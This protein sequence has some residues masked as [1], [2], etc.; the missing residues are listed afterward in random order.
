[1]G[2]ASSKRGAVSFAIRHEGSVS[3]IAKTQRYN[4]LLGTCDT[5]REL[6][7]GR[8]LKPRSFN[9]FFKSLATKRRAQATQ[10]PHR[11]DL[12]PPRRL[13]RGGPRPPLDGAPRYERHFHLPAGC[14]R[15]PPSPSA[16]GPVP[17]LTPTPSAGA[18][19]QPPRPLTVGDAPRPARRRGLT[20]CRPAREAAIAQRGEAMEAEKEV[21]RARTPFGRRDGALPAAGRRQR[22]GR[23]GR[24]GR[25]A[26]A[27]AGA[28][29]AGRW[30][31]RR[32]PLP[33]G[34]WRGGAAAAAAGAA[35]V[36][37]GACRR[38]EEGLG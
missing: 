34:G 11:G 9:K 37:A 20:G 22:R 18:A 8:R 6:Y 2:S 30:R 15:R 21:E 26:A 25:P 1:M 38:R 10:V 31:R 24:G 29:V 32:G 5:L 35:A 33:A 28:R 23:A 4:S 14:Y 16:A 7:K 3:P 17:G 19:Q 27:E 13:P 12:P 36:I